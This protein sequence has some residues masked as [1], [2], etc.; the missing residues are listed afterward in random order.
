MSTQVKEIIVDPY[1]GFY[2]AI[3]PLNANNAIHTLIRSILNSN[4]ALHLLELPK[5][6]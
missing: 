5:A 2:S 6:K 1:S 4:H 3:M